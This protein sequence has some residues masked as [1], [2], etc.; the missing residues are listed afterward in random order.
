VSTAPQEYPYDERLVSG[1][2]VRITELVWAD[3]HRSYQVHIVDNDTDGNTHLTENGCF[4]NPPTDT[5][6]N[7]LLAEHHAARTL[8][9]DATRT[10]LL[11]DLLVT[12]SAQIGWQVDLDQL[13]VTCAHT[14]H[15]V[16]ALIDASAAHLAALTTQTAL[17][18]AAR[19]I[20]QVITA[21]DP[22]TVDWL[23]AELF[24][25]VA[26]LANSRSLELGHTR[27]ALTSALR[28]LHEE[29]AAW[30]P[31]PGAADAA[32]RPADPAEPA[33]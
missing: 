30:P 15:L 13:P 7:D 5:L 28:A 2:P 9:G 6:I 22:G 33:H 12:I 26:Q 18:E 19:S 8:R 27:R 23:A 32:S 14:P 20:Q 4:D 31:N 24:G 16:V 25:A 1:V 10:D 17:T 21:G 29:G 3:E 11:R